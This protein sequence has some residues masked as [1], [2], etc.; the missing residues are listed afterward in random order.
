MPRTIHVGTSGWV[1]SEW[2]EVFH[3]P[4]LKPRDRRSGSHTLSFDSHSAK[5]RTTRREG[6]AWRGKILY[7]ID[8]KI[9]SFDLIVVL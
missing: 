6:F 8:W 2:A 9:R 3:P 1:Y 5:L 7:K 4:K